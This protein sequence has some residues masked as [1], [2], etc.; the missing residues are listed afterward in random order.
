MKIQPSFDKLPEA[1]KKV[2]NFNPE[3]GWKLNS[4]DV[5]SSVVIEAAEL[6]EIFQWKS[7][8][9]KIDNNDPEVKAHLAQE[10]ADVMIYLFDLCDLQNIDFVDAIEKKVNYNTEK[11]PISMAKS[12]NSDELYFQQKKK[13]RE[14][15]K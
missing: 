5:A 6:L 4:H 11:Y 7:C 2:I 1:Y 14:I 9:D 10:I 13:Y 3:R 12:D 8:R 15:K